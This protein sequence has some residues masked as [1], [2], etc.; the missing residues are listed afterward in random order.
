MCV[1]NAALVRVLGARQPAIPCVALPPAW[2]DREHIRPVV[3][4]AIVQH[5]AGPRAVEQRPPARGGPLYRELRAPRHVWEVAF[6]QGIFRQVR[7]GVGGTSNSS[8][9]RAA[10]SHL[11]L[12]GM[13]AYSAVHGPTNWAPG[14]GQTP[15]SR[16]GLSA[17]SGS[18]SVTPRAVPASLPPCSAAIGMRVVSIP[19]VSPLGQQRSSSKC[20][21]GVSLVSSRSCTVRMRGLQSVPHPVQWDARRNSDKATRAF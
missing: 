20:H 21:I 10:S 4:R 5:R 6:H 3:C 13:I 7:R 17:C 19:V 8:A 18:G 14:T 15:L 9:Q 1:R 16:S 12:C 11:P 2:L